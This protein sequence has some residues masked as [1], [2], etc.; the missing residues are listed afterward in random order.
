MSSFVRSI[1][2][3]PI[4]LISI[5][6]VVLYKSN[7]VLYCLNS[8]L[9]TSVKFKILLSISSSKEDSST[10]SVSSST[11]SIDLMNVNLKFLEK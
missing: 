9:K 3:L 11:G 10:I 4:V 5:S 6:N 1:N 2:L 7:S 8:V